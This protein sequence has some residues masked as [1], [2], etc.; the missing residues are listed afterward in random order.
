MNAYELADW[1]DT[2][3]SVGEQDSKIMFQISTMLRQQ[4]DKLAEIK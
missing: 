2:F 3:S 4:A 1:L